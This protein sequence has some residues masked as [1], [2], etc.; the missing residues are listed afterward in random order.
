MKLTH[1]MFADDLLLFS[2]GDAQSMMV[3]VRS[4]CSFSQASGLKMDQQKSCA[5]FNGV[6]KSLAGDILGVSGFKEGNLPIKYLG[7]PITVGRLKKQD[8]AV[9]IDKIMGRIRS[10]GAWDRVHYIYL[11]GTHWLDYKPS[12]NVSWHWRKICQIHNLIKE[13]FCENVWIVGNGNYSVKG[14]YN[15]MRNPK[16]SVDWY[17]SVWNG[18]GIPKHKFM[19]WLLMQHALRLKD[20]LYH[21]GI[22]PDDH[23]CIYYAAAE[24]NEHLMNDC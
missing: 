5:Y 22:A 24:T 16:P 7:V 8:C 2:K 14:C 9:L 18:V 21:L 23:C 6:D 19:V 10:L 15:W 3:L 17:M 12:S 11:K 20:K 13:G 4:L 1:L